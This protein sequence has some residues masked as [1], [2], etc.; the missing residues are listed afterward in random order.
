MKGSLIVF[1]VITTLLNSGCSYVSQV[2]PLS[3]KH[4]VMLGKIQ[5]IGGTIIMPGKKKYGFDISDYSG[6]AG[7]GVIGSSGAI[8]YDIHGGRNELEEC[9]KSHASPDDLIKID[10]YYFTTSFIIVPITLLLYIDCR[11]TSGVQGA[12]YENNRG[13]ESEKTKLK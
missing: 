2:G 8:E 9:N 13:K 7:W 4:P 3:V 1:I 10:N 6:H 12:V 5:N 11:I